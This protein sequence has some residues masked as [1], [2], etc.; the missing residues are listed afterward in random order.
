MDLEKREK[1][2]ALFDIY[3]SLLTDK[4]KGYFTDYYFLDL[5]LAEIAENYE[6]SRNAVFDQIKKTILI[7]EDY[8]AK[9]HLLER[10]NKLE[11]FMKKLPSELQEELES[12]I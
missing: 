10:N 3:E 12:I 6:V 2:I 5:S 11:E 9:L 1:E 7:L 8:E 4:Q